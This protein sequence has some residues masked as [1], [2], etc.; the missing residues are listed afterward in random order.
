LGKGA[1]QNYLKKQHIPYV[2]LLR[3]PQKMLIFLDILFF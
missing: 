1:V 3:N 2:L